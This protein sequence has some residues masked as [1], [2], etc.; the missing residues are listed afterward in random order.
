MRPDAWHHRTVTASSD[1]AQLVRAANNGD[2][3][4]WGALVARYAGLIWSIALSYRLSAADAAD[5]S[6]T[7]WLTAVEHLKDVRDPE[8]IAGWLAT[9]TRREALRVLRNHG[10]EV[11]DDLSALLA[12]IADPATAATD[13]GILSRELRDLVR[14]AFAGLPPLCQELLR[15]LMRDPPVPYAEI[16]AVVEMPVGSIGPTRQRCLRRLRSVLAPSVG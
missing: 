8:H 1:P 14:A 13:E 4:A 5:I 15:L 9:T 12:G 10:R 2:Q 11:P 3:Q 6:Q 16:A 7:V